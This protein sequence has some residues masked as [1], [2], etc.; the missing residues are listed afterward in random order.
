MHVNFK[1]RRLE[2]VL[3]RKVEVFHLGMTSLDFVNKPKH[4]TP[5]LEFIFMSL[6]AASQIVA[7][8][9]LEVTC[10]LEPK[11]ACVSGLA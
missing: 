9:S 5:K 2:V 10:I 6:K 11:C 7:S 4:M 1:T 3:A 8:K